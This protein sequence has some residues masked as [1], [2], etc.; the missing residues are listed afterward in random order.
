MKVTTKRSRFT[1]DQIAYALRQ[2]DGGTAV[3][4]VFRQMGISEAPFYVWKK[5]HAAWG[6]TGIRELRPQRE[7]NAKLK[8]LVAD[9]SLDKHSSRNRRG[10]SSLLPLLHW[11]T[12]KNGVRR[13]QVRLP[14]HRP[15]NLQRTSQ[16]NWSFAH[17]TKV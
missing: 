5:K 14:N 9:L 4:A 13:L 3:A 16:L 11:R 15:P 6:S 2:V 10:R 1:D 8:R 12:D 7:E 17:G